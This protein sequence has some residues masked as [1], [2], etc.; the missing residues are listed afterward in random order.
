MSEKII[1]FASRLYPVLTT[2]WFPAKVLADLDGSSD[3]YNN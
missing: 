1:N 3:G 2:V